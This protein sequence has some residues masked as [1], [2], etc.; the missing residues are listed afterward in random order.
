MQQPHGH[1]FMPVL[2][3]CSSVLFV[4]GIART[5]ELRNGTN[6]YSG[7]IHVLIAGVVPGGVCGTFFSEPAAEVA[8]RQLGFGPL[9]TIYPSGSFGAEK[10]FHYLRLQ[11]TG[12]E[13]NFEECRN[14]DA[15]VP[16]SSCPGSAHAAI[17][18]HGERN[19]VLHFATDKQ[20]FR[21]LLDYRRFT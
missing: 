17:E 9:K 6:K 3:F 10:N 5:I 13:N 16:S 15:F 2:S 19:L 18:C 14:S 12:M 1:T 20:P 8:C 7:R 11:C 21:S 4:T